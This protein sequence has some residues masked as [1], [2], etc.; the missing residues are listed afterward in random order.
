MSKQTHLE[1]FLRKVA[2]VRG[3][4]AS[5]PETSYYPAFE[6][7][8][9]GIGTTLSPRVRA[10]IHIQDSGGG[11]PDGG[12]FIDRPKGLAGLQNPLSTAPERGVLE[13]KSPALVLSKVIASKQVRRYLDRYGAVLVSN[14]REWSLLVPDPSTGAA[15][16]LE[17]YLL[18]GSEADF[19]TIANHPKASAADHE[20][21]FAEFL[22][23]VLQH[24]AAL[25][26][27]EDVAWFLAA[28]A[29]LAM[30]RIQN[31]DMS[32]LS[33]VRTA[34]Q[35]SLGLKF[36]GTEGEHFFQSTLVQTLFYGIFSAWVLWAHSQPE[37]VNKRFFWHEAV[38]WLNVPMVRVLFHQIATPDT[39]GSLDLTELMDWSEEVLNRVDREQFFG[40][41][42]HTQAVQYFYEPFL[43]AFDPDLRKQLGVW[44]TPHEVVRYMVA[45]VDET[46][47]TQFGLTA[48]LA[49]PNVYVLD[50][51]TGTG[52]YLIEVLKTIAETISDQGGDALASS[53]LKQAAMHRVVGFEVLPA[54]FVIAHL[55][56]GLL[57]SDY[58]APL[59]AK[60]GERAAVYLTNS[61]TGWID[62]PNLTHLPFAELEEERDVATAIKQDAPILVVLGNPPYNGFAGVSPNEEGDL[63]A[64]YKEGLKEQW[65]V[66]KNSLDDLYVRFF[67]IAE[68]RIVDG[69]GKGIV[70]YIS[71]YSYL[72]DPT[73]VVMRQHLLSEF[74][75]ISIDCLNG[76]SR[77]TGKRTPDGK[78]DP[79]IFST[80][81]NTAGIR[82]GTAIGLYVRHQVRSAVPAVRFRH[83]WGANKREQL[84]ESIA[85]PNTAE[86]YSEVQP[87]QSNRFSLRPFSTPPAYFD[88]PA[89]P[90]LCKVAP[91]LGLNEN[92]SLA[93]IDIDIKK[94]TARLKSYFNSET[95]FHE[96][97]PEVGGLAKKYASFNPKDVRTKLLTC[98]G[99]KPD[100]M[101][102]YLFKP[103][104][105]RWAYVETKTNIWNRARPD[106]VA[107]AKLDTRFLLVR[108][109][110]PRATDG[111]ALLFSRN[112]GDMD[113]VD[114]HAYYIPFELPP[115]ESAHP[116]LFDNST[117]SVM[118]NLSPNAKSY[119]TTLGIDP[120]EDRYGEILWLH[121]L[122]VGYS[123]LYLSENGDGIRSNWPRIPL[124]VSQELLQASAELGD[125]IAALVDPDGVV[126]GVTSSVSDPHKSLGVVER[127]DIPRS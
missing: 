20:Q 81:R 16:R 24:D 98:G 23:R 45:K 9:T 82:V 119:L 5:L 83:F 29:R 49:N 114:G 47:R 3:T 93:L 80:P 42:E 1:T 97:P 13:I 64:P 99:F 112:L 66:T 90:E 127:L 57:L 118:P 102:R 89:L 106:L 44:Y 67:R 126:E 53:D 70:S 17:S 124:P 10:V 15:K 63:V 56:L 95:G 58:G 28:Y 50:P 11:I 31:Q 26:N 113:C 33:T 55:Q 18:A 40:K 88:W 79:S 19:W 116:K 107:Q 34:V 48:G 39:L 36:E 22:Q 92:R 46:L 60:G 85:E 62:D 51:C 108:P 35:E 61:L 77:E 86:P 73:Y 43:Q 96:L 105:V 25:S 94:L 91:S 8:L 109:T 123:P 76:D 117:K 7:L 14:F 122:A 72:S 4:G 69:V 2:K 37:V 65:G 111:S 125:R 38:W 103:M 71:N 120:E 6:E 110:T 41:F 100:N 12:L 59:N 104:D 21:K 30:E 78:P 121:A 87:N 75:D 54:S 68:R 27:P 101:M 52:S 115:D 74:D 84:V 32:T